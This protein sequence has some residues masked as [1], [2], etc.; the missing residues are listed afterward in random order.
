MGE[1]FVKE[2]DGEGVVKEGTGITT[3]AIRLHRA[4]SKNA[5]YIFKELSVYIYFFVKLFPS[6]LWISTENRTKL[7]KMLNLNQRLK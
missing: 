2:G 5:D 6:S 1:G 3:P 4:T 7:K